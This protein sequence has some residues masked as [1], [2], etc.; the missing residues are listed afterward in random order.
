[1]VMRSANERF[2]L[3]HGIP[4]RLRL[5]APA[6]FGEERLEAVARRLGAEPEIDAVRTN[7]LTGSLVVHFCDP[8]R[9]LPAMLA[10]LGSAGVSVADVRIDE[11][12]PVQWPTSYIFSPEFDRQ[13]EGFF[14]PRTLVSGLVPLVAVRWFELEGWVA[15][16]VWIAVAAALGEILRRIGP[17]PEPVR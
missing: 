5:K 16:A 6:R 9:S 1:M 8:S 14:Q 13:L 17:Q 10:R 15:I 11:S 7:A 4:G 12:A 3:I 2:E